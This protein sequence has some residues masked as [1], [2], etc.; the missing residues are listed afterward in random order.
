MS[1]SDVVSGDSHLTEKQCGKKRESLA[2]IEEKIQHAEE[3]LRDAVAAGRGGI[4]KMHKRLELLTKRH[5]HLLGKWKA[6]EV[7]KAAKAKARL[8]KKH[9]SVSLNDLKIDFVCAVDNVQD[10]VGDRVEEVAKLAEVV[11]RM[12][13]KI[14]ANERNAMK[15]IDRTNKLMAEN[16]KTRILSKLL[17]ATRPKFADK[18]GR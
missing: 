18:Y 17:K 4:A 5:A 16:T 7:A 12:A 1:G 3:S 13:D 14:V 11:E 15:M 9:L 10:C 2:L 6:K 8:E